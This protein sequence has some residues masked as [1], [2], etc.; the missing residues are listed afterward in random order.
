MTLTVHQKGP[1]SEDEGN[2]WDNDEPLLRPDSHTGL[3]SEAVLHS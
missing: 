3:H 2:K 1:V